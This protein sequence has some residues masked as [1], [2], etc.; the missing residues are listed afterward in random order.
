M[1]SVPPANT[2]G[3]IAGSSSATGCSPASPTN[4]GL[5]EPWRPGRR[6]S[7][8]FVPLAA[9]DT[10]PIAAVK[11]RQLPIYGL[12]FHPEVTP[13]AATARQSCGISSTR[14]C[15]CR[16]RWQ[17]GDLCPE[18]IVADPPAGRRKPRH[19]RAVRRGRFVRGGGPADPG[20]RGR[21]SRA[22]SSITA[23]CARRSRSGAS[24]TFR[25]HF[26][27]DLHVVEAPATFPRRLGRRRRSAG[28]TPPHRPCVHRRLQGRGPAH[29]EARFLAQGTLYPDVIE[30]GGRRRRA[31][32]HDQ[33]APQRRRTA[34]A[35]LASS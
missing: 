13:Y 14:V 23:C 4:P 9:T 28:K 26:K 18:T 27:A 3:P 11:H 25:D 31:R 8:D 6:S 34:R 1:A 5:D 22:S 30:S 24:T 15:G 32:R 17:L 2:A 33:D 19:L 35:N 21:R 10:C 20:D 16:A 29:R 7:G 12:Q